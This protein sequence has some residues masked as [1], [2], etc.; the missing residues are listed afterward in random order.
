M[1]S[2]WFLAEEDTWQQNPSL[3]NCIKFCSVQYFVL[4][5]DSLRVWGKKLSIPKWQAVQLPLK[6]GD[7]DPPQQPIFSSTVW[8]I[9]EVKQEEAGVGGRSYPIIPHRYHK[10]IM[11]RWSH[12]RQTAQLEWLIS[13]KGLILSSWR[14]GADSSG[15]LRG[16]PSHNLEILLP[17]CPFSSIQGSHITWGWDQVN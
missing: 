6:M 3:V 17:L 7:Q 12:Q 16:V 11:G 1:W 5:K 13:G 14:L 4:S 8:I 15:R 9:M 2:S 10:S